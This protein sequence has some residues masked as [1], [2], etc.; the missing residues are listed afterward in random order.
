MIT[1]W[2]MDATGVHSEGQLCFLPLASIC[3]QAKLRGNTMKV[4]LT[5]TPVWVKFNTTGDRLWEEEEEPR[6]PGSVEEM[7]KGQR[8]NWKEA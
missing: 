1:A 2:D 8:G 5:K 6:A 3:G 7:G 4:S